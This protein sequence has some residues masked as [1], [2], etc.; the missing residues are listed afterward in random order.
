MIKSAQL[1]DS[2]RFRHQLGFVRLG[3][4]LESLLLKLVSDFELFGPFLG[5]L[6]C[7]VADDALIVDLLVGLELKDGGAEVGLNGGRLSPLV[8]ELALEL[9]LQVFIPRLGGSKL[10]TDIL[11]RLLELGVAHLDQDRVR[12]DIGSGKDDD[13][14]DSPLG[15]GGDPANLE[16][17]QSPRP[18]NLSK[19]GAP[20]D[21]VHPDCG[22]IDRRGGRLEPRH[23]ESQDGEQKTPADTEGP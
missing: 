12:L 18:P 7:E 11:C 9:D 1:V 13:A 23:P 22:T 5:K 21:A 19:H 10:E 4:D 17:H 16:R 8:Q 2:G 14:L 15:A 6:E 3:G 20:S